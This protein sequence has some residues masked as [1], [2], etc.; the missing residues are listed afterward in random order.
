MLGSAFLTAL[1]LLLGRGAV[2]L[3]ALAQNIIN[4]RHH[5][6]AFKRGE[7]GN[8]QHDLPAKVILVAGVAVRALGAGLSRCGWR[9]LSHDGFL[10]VDLYILPLKKRPHPPALPGA[11]AWT[12]PDW[13]WNIINKPMG[14]RSQGTGAEARPTDV[15]PGKDCNGKCN[16]CPPNPPS[17]DHQ[18]DAHGSSRGFHTHQWQYHQA[19]DCICRA[20]KVSW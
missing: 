11:A 5:L 4:Q 13:M 20:R 3:A 15:N 12:L 18:G 8:Q 7:L 10:S 19:P 9:C 6:L 16:P 14:S 17:F 1:A 2:R